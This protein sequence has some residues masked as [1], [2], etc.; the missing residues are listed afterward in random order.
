MKWKLLLLLIFA[1]ISRIPAY[2]ADTT[3]YVSP[4]GRG[5]GRRLAPASLEKAVDWLPRLKK[6]IGEGAINIVLEE[7]TYELNKTIYITSANG[8]TKNIKIV[9]TADVNAHPVIS[10]GREILLTGQDVLS[11]NISPLL[12]DGSPQ[13]I[14]VNGNRAV[15]AR[16]PDFGFLTFT[17]VSEK[18][19]ADIPGNKNTF[20]QYFEIPQT[21]YKQLEALTPQQ[22]KRVRVNIYHKW[23]A[24]IRT[25]DSLS[26]TSPGFYA[27]GP[28][29]APYNPI[30]EKSY[31]FLDN[32]AHALDIKNEWVLEPNNV[33]KYIPDESSK[34]KLEAI[35]PIIEKLLII[36]GNQN[37]PVNNIYFNGISFCYANNAFTGF[38]DSQ[39]ASSI[40]A[41]IM[42]DNARN[43]H[44]QN[45]SIRHTG[46]YAIWFRKNV[47]Y[48]NMEKCY[49][50]DLGAGGIRIGETRLPEDTTDFTSYIK[51]ENCI[52]HSGGYDYP[53]AVGVFIADAAHNIIDHNDI[54]DFRYTGV[55][56]GWVWGY[57][58]SP[59][60]DNKIIYNH[61]HHI[62]WGVL[63]DM[64]GVYTLGVSPG[65]EVSHNIINDVYSFDYGGWGLYPDE[66]SSE[67]RMEDNLVYNTKTG[68]FHQHYGRN[69]RINNNIFA[70]GKEYLAQDS[71]IENH[72]SFEFKHNI[73]LSDGETFFQGCWK[74]GQVAIDSNCYW[75]LKHTKNPFMISTMEYGSGPV[76]TFSFKQWQTAS[77]RDKHSL[78]V[79]PGFK[80]P[81]KYN[82]SIKNNYL[83]HQIGFKSFDYTKAGVT[84]DKQWR[85]LAVLPD[86]II[87]K[88]DK[89][90]SAIMLK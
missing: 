12:K 87:Q 46:Q 54:A 35:I 23:T 22:L 31:F 5:S 4:E 41:A 18:K 21:T 24:T 25:I 13:D 56:V 48:C 68:S 60:V 28:A 37:D 33:V 79:N 6:I 40:D 67:I 88:F 74:N 86:D 2:S 32:D 78:F 83:L 55:S 62:G 36:K 58:Y 43:I 27:T 81:Q 53:S 50:D 47:K 51:I 20:L 11:A 85:K 1:A 16:I 14:Y 29:W 72:L 69:N 26:T 82:F 90:V 34:Q 49:I 61:I 77:G 17:K 7:G 42:I 3:L 19:L 15:R 45:C 71:R 73:L 70:F 76:D 84:G 59:S 38:N 80:H 8:G 30:D 63:S 39:A 89:S 52:I 57:S 10:G 75:R 64:G 66:G 9:F 44:F 65:T